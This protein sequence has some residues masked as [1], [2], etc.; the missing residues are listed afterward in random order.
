MIKDHSCSSF[1][2][3]FTTYDILLY[4]MYYYILYI[5]VQYILLYMIYYYTVYIYRGH[6]HRILCCVWGLT[7]LLACSRVWFQTPVDL[8]GSVYFQVQA[9]GP[10]PHCVDTCG[11]T[12][13]VQTQ[14]TFLHRIL[15]FMGTSPVC[16]NEWMSWRLCFPIRWRIIVTPCRLL[17]SA[18]AWLKVCVFHC[19]SAVG[20]FQ[21]VNNASMEE[22]RL[23][24]RKLH[25]RIESGIMW[26]C[27]RVC[28]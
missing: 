28:W 22:G 6:F 5:T 20:R 26:T 18:F 10:R 21:N 12:S 27:G 8:C 3:P 2:S 1:G 17:I 7:L 14:L 9:H 16:V 15:S 11:N 4:S 24:A 25:F 13:S 23:L 19:F